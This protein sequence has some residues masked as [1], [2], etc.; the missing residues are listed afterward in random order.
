MKTI[1]LAMLMASIGTGARCF[2]QQQPVGMLKPV[3]VAQ[4]LQLPTNIQSIYVGGIMEGMGFVTYGYGLPD[5]PDWVR[6][7]RGK[8]LG[9]TTQDVV[10]FIRNTPDFSEGVAS[11]LA[12]TL[13]RRCKTAR[14]Q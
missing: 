6:C 5:Y 10:S 14:H 12:Q 7:V 8:T 13:G 11:A 3:P 4:F 9:E 2:A 1:W